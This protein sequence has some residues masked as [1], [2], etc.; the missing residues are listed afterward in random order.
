MRT[1]SHIIKSLGRQPLADLVTPC[2]HHEL[3]LLF[4]HVSS[5]PCSHVDAC[6]TSR[7]HFFRQEEGEEGQ[8][9]RSIQENLA[10][11]KMFLENS[12]VSSAYLSLAR[13]GSWLCIATREPRKI[14]I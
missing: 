3:R 7:C 9:R 11:L 8:G 5:K 13:S 14:N 6:C 4:F 10:L 2:C 1:F 12:P